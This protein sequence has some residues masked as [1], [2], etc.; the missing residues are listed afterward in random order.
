MHTS[1]KENI[2][3]NIAKYR[4]QKGLSQNALAEM[5]G[6]KNFTTV[7]SWERGISS[8]DADTIIKLCELLDITLYD[9]YEVDNEQKPLSPA[10]KELLRKYSDLDTHGKKMVDFVLNE[11]SKRSNSKKGISDLMYDDYELSSTI[12]KAAQTPTPYTKD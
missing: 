1:I 4:K 11:E 5:V 10:Q 6:A 2:S 9:L 3:K 8:P 7:S 12:Q